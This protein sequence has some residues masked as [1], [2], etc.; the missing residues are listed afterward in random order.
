[1]KSLREKYII[2]CHN[3]VCMD[4]RFP[5]LVSVPH[6]GDFVPPEIRDRIRLGEDEIAFHSDPGTRRL[7]NFGE[8]ISGFID[9]CIS[10]A[11]IDLNRAPYDRPPANPDGVIKV[12]TPEG[13]PV[14]QEGAFPPPELIRSLLK[15]YYYPYH[16]EINS[17]LESGSIKIA[18]DC[19]SMTPVA[20][21][22]YP[23]A[24]KPR[25]LI[26]LGNQGNLRGEPAL[27]GTPLTCPPGWIRLMADFFREEFDGEGT[28][29]INDPFPG[30][31][32]IRS[33]FRQRR[34]P[35]V[36]IEVNRKLYESGDYS[37]PETLTIDPQDVDRL[38]ERI[39]SALSAFWEN[40]NA[41]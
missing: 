22:M 10:R 14:Y 18:F 27:N 8:R 40:L 4:S 34:I 25:P 12:M 2:R 28:V 7:F 3:T 37:D 15:T 35:W 26:C 33:H 38:R 32:T 17:C 31:F 24:G 20:P 29:A 19:H 39:F 30:G 21:P 9:A 41:V 23:N 6:G 1:M 16:E 11:V 13:F 36:Q 5:F